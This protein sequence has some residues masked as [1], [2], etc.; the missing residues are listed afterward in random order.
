MGRNKG[1]A[2]WALP[3]REALC[4]RG[5]REALRLRMDFNLLS[6]PLSGNSPSTHFYPWWQEVGGIGKHT[7]VCWLN[8]LGP[9][10]KCSGRRLVWGRNYEGVLMTRSAPFDVFPKNWCRVSLVKRWKDYKFLWAMKLSNNGVV[11]GWDKLFRQR[12]TCSLCIQRWFILHL[13]PSTITIPIP[14]LSLILR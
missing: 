7:A 11:G 2:Q 1:E 12:N 5:G 3:K 4:P 13:F 9:P 6:L 10:Q 14:C 8:I